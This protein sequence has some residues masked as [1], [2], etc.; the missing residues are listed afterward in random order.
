M[1]ISS[2]YQNWQNKKLYKNL[3]TQLNKNLVNFKARIKQYKQKDQKHCNK[4]LCRKI[5][6]NPKNNQKNR[7]LLK[8]KR[9]LI[10]NIFLLLIKKKIFKIN[11]KMN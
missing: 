6:Q 4:I 3:M 11:N 9:Y 8:I 1:N 7:F 2:F 10:K 5:L